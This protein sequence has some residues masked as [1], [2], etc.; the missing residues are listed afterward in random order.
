MCVLDTCACIF[1]FDTANSF[2]LCYFIILPFFSTECTN[3]DDEAGTAATV[4]DGVCLQESSLRTA[5]VDLL[6]AATTHS[7]DAHKTDGMYGSEDQHYF[8]DIDMA[9]LG[10]SP[11]H[12][13]EYAAKVQQEYAFLPET[14]YRNLR[15]KVRI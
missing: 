14:T 9:V 5:V 12:Y 1:V 6:H 4:Q 13:S 11:E 3:Y 15:L 7:T 2:V 10:S 8:L